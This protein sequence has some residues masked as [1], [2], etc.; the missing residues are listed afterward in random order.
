MRITSIP[1]F[2]DSRVGEREGGIRSGRKGV[3]CHAVVFCGFLE[4]GREGG[5]MRRGRWELTGVNS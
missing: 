3:A 1:G 2:Y 5:I 4:L